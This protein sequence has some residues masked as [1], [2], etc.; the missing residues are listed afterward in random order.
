MMNRSPTANGSKTRYAGSPSAHVPASLAGTG[1]WALDGTALIEK[2]EMMTK[3]NKSWTKAGTVGCNTQEGLHLERLSDVLNGH[4]PGPWRVT[5]RGDGHTYIE[6]AR[7]KTAVACMVARSDGPEENTANARLIAAAPQ[8]LEA[9]EATLS[10]YCQLRIRLS[11]EEISRIDA[12]A[13]VDIKHQARQ[14]IE[15]ARGR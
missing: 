3:A 2:D 12:Q 8:L 13:A 9:L 10:A 1:R 15:A 14:A 6:D 7:Y 4:T 11:S 5:K